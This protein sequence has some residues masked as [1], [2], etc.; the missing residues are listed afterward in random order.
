MRL[1]GAIV[2]HD[3]DT[4]FFKL[5]GS[6]DAVEP[7]QKPFEDFVRS[8]R[9][10]RPDEPISW[11]LPE[12]WERLPDK[13][14]GDRY[15]TLHVGPKDAPL[16]LSVHRY[17]DAE[18]MRSIPAN[19]IRWGKNDVGLVVRRDEWKYYT[20]DDKTA[21]GGLS[22]TFVDMKGPGGTGG[23][24]KPPFAGGAN[25]HAPAADEKLTYTVPEGWKEADRV[26]RRGGI[27]VRYE[28]A[29]KVEEGGASALLTVS[30]FP[31]GAGG[32]LPN[33]NRWRDQV[34]LPPLSK[35][36]LFKVGTDV[37]VGDSGGLAVDFKG[38]ERRVLGVVAPREGF[39]WFIKMDGPADLVE[40]QKPAFDKF[41][42]S[43]KFDGGK[44][45]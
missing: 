45:G 17:G 21:E 43:V 4:W 13:P 1:L 40:K 42:G 25:P 6:P 12:G 8:V 14:G 31:E 20:H 16:D 15:A 39:T 38:R 23:G 3:K 41:V 19:V 22:V 37:K 34:G 29:L 26:V 33:V 27:E 30:K 9:F 2:P 7:L 11:K 36:E 32:L 28:A 5:V 18:Q 10:D 44:G 35:E 24:M